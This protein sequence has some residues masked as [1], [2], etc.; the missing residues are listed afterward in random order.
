[1]LVIWVYFE[2]RAFLFSHWS[3][4]VFI[5]ACNLPSIWDDCL[6]EI[7]VCFRLFN[8]VARVNK[9]TRMR[10]RVSQTQGRYTMFFWPKIVLLSSLDLERSRAMKKVVQTAFGVCLTVYNGRNCGLFWKKVTRMRPLGLTDPWCYFSFF[11][12]SFITN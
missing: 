6:K 2:L 7:I 5:L 1:M 9:I 8:P 11:F 3:F 12:H 4:T 10:T